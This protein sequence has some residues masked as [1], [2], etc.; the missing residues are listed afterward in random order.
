MKCD[1]KNGQLLH[2]LSGKLHV[3]HEFEKSRCVVA[4]AKRYRIDGATGRRRDKIS[5]KR[6]PP[7]FPVS[8]TKTVRI[9]SSG[10]Q[11]RIF[12]RYYDNR[13]SRCPLRFHRT[14]AGETLQRGMTIDHRTGVLVAPRSAKECAHYLASCI[15]L[16][17]PNV[18]RPPA[19]TARSGCTGTR[20]CRS[21]LFVR[22]HEI[23]TRIF[24]TRTISIR[25]FFFFFFCR[26]TLY[27]ILRV[28]IQ[29]VLINGAEVVTI[30]VR[31]SLPPVYVWCHF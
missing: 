25:L 20:R 22:V 26:H 18:F 9:A 12:V 30:L 17:V 29:D 3:L 23:V 6:F 15:L 10:R 24:Y 31:S 19:H 11:V 5:A 16:L 7:S 13:H 1:S 8:A 28:Q 21:R 14:D 2:E 4:T 27:V